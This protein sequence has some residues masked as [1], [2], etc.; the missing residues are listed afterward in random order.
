MA[1]IAAVFTLL[2]TTVAAIGA[3]PA[4]AQGLAEVSI[5]DI[6]VTE[7]N[8]VPP[9][10]YKNAL[11]T[12]SVSGPRNGS[13][14]VVY[15]TFDTGSATA[16]VD[17]RDFSQTVTISAGQS[18]VTRA[19]RVYGDT[20]PEPTETFEVRLSNP[21]NATIGNGTAVVTIND[22]DGYVP[23]AGPTISVADASVTEGDT[24]GTVDVSLTLS[25]AA[26]N[27]V[28]VDLATSNGS[29]VAGS[30]Y[31]AFSGTVTF[32]ANQTTIQQSIG[33]IGDT[34]FE[35]T[36]DFTVTL[37]N[38]SGATISDGSA[39]V[40]ITDN[41]PEPPGVPDLSVS[42][43]TVG[44]GDG[45]V[46]VTITADETS[47]SPVTFDLATADGT[48]TAGA[49]YTA[50]ST[51]VTLPANTLSV[52][53]VIT[54][55]EDT[56]SE[57]AEDFDVVISNVVGGTIV[58]GTGV[59]TIN[60]NDAPACS[61]GP[62]VTVGDVTVT[63]AEFEVN[64]L[65]TFTRS[66]VSGQSTRFF[67]DSID[68]TAVAPGDYTARS[69]QLVV[70]QG[71][72]TTKTLAFKIQGDTVAEP[73]ETFT[74]QISNPT[75][76][77]IDPNNDS[78][79]ITIVDNDG[80]AD[81]TISIS[82]ASTT[83]TDGTSSVDLTLSLDQTS[84][85]PV[86]VE[87]STQNGSAL[88]GSDFV[89]QAANTV[90]IP[91][92]NL[93]G[94]VSIDIIGDDD[95]EPTETFTVN[96][97]NPSGA[98]IGDGSATV[99]ILDD[100]PAPPAV[101]VEDASTT[102]TDGSSTVDV[103]V[104]LDQVAASPVTVLLSTSD[105]T[106]TAGADY[107]AVASQL[108]TIPAG[109]LNTNVA[110]SIVGDD[111][112]EPTE[113]FTVNI[114][115]P[116][117]AILGDSTGTVTIND[118]E[119]PPPVTPQISIADASTTETD[120]PS[121]VDVTVSLD[122]Q[123]SN[124]VTVDVATADGSAT[125]GNDYLAAGPTTVTFNPG[126]TQKT[127]SIDIVGDTNSEPVEDFAVNLSNP[128]LGVIADGSATVT[129][130]DN[131]APACS[132]GPDVTVGD[133]TVTETEFELNAIVTFTRAFS[134]NLS[135]RFFVNTI[136]GTA[137][138]PGDYTA[139]TNQLVVINGGQTTKTLAFKIQGDTVAEPVESF[140]VEISN[141][142][143]GCIDPNNNT[144]TVTIVDN[145]GPANPSVSVADVSTTE[146][147]GPSTV[148]ATVSIDFAI[149]NP[150]TVDLTTVDGTA[151]SGSDYVA[152]SATTVTIPAGQTSVAVPIGIVGDE[153]F[154]PTE[155]FT[156]NLTN[157]TNATIG[158]GTGTVTINDDEPT[159]PAVSIADATTTETDT[160]STVDVTVSLDNTSTNPVTVLLSTAD[161]T[162]TAPDDYLTTSGQLVTIP[163]NTSSVTVALDIVGDDIFEPT[164]SFTATLSSPTNAII[165]DGSATIT[166]TD[167][168]DPPPN[169][170][171]ADASTTETDTA[172]TVDVIVSLDATT[173]SPV[174]VLLS[175]SDGTA[176]AP[177]D[178]TAETNL[179]VTIPANTLS[180]TVP[181]NIAGDD[182]YEQTETFTVSLSS[183]T[184][185]FIGDG[186]AT[187]GILDDE[188][189]PPGAS[190]ADASV[191]ETDAATT[192]DLTITLDSPSPSVATVLLSTA[193]GTAVAP[194]DYTA[195]TDQL[196]TI[197]ANTSSVTVSLDI[198]GD[199]V[200]E[201][202]EEFTVTLSSPTNV[203]IGDGTATVTIT[204]NDP[205][206]P[207][208]PQISIADVSTT[209]TETSATVDVTVSFDVPTSNTVTVDL[210][211]ADGTALAGSDYTAAGP[212]TLT[213]APGD[214]S[215]TVT[216]DI[217]GDLV[218]ES[219]EDFTVNLSNAVDG[220]IAD[221]SATVTIF[222]ND[223]SLCGDG[224][225]ITVQDIAV[226]EG[227]S[228]TKN[229]AVTFNASYPRG[230]GEGSVRFDVNSINGTATAPSDFA[231]RTNQ[232]VVIAETATSKT[233]T[234]V[235]N[236]DTLEEGDESFLIEISNPL[237]G[238]IDPN[239][240]TGTFTILGDDG[241]PVPQISIADVTTAETNAPSTVDVTVSVDIPST[242]PITVQLDTVDGTAT[243]PGDYLA[244]VAQTVTIP[245]NATSVTYPLNIVGDMAFEQTEEFQ[246]AL[247]SPSSNAEIADGT[248]TVTITDADPAVGIPEIS[249]ADVTIAEDDV[250]VTATVTVT[251]DEVDDVPVT[252]Q[253]DTSDG[254]AT[255]PA[256]YTAVTAATV[257][258]PVGQLSATQDITIIGDDL[259]E[260]GDETFTVTLSNNSGDSI[261]ADP[262]ATVTITDD[263]F[264]APIPAQLSVLDVSVEESNGAPPGSTKNVVVTF[265]L[266][267]GSVDPVGQVR[268]MW[269]T[270]DTGSATEGTDYPYARSVDPND[271][272]TDV[273]VVIPAPVIG[274]APVTRTR[275]IQIY[276]DNLPEPDETFE[277]HLFDVTPN[278][279]VAKGIGVVT[280]ED[281]DGPPEISIDD[282]TVNEGDPNATLTLSLDRTIGNQIDVQVDTADG[283]AT[284]GSDYVAVAA[285]VVSFPANTQTVTV[286][287]PLLD[288]SAFE[289]DEDFTVNLS[290][291]VNA[292]IVD[293]QGVV[294]ISD[295]ESTPQISIG[296]VSA[297]EG[298]ATFKSVLLNITLD[299]TSSEEIT[300]RFGTVNGTAVGGVET[301]IPLPDFQRVNGSPTS[302]PLLTF[303]PGETTKT[304]SI[305][306]FGDTE[307]EVDE[308]FTVQLYAPT[309]ATFLDDSATVTIVD[310]DTTAGI[311]IDDLVVLE[312]DGSTPADFVLA[313]VT[314]SL[315]VSSDG[316]V[317]VQ[318]DSADGTAVAGTDYEAITA[319]PVTFPANTTTLTTEVKVFS[320]DVEDGNRDFVLNLSNPV[321]GAIVDG[322]AT[323]TIDDNEDLPK[324]SVADLSVTEGDG[325]APNDFVN[326]DVTVSLDSPS[327]TAATVQ[328]D[329]SAG[330]ATAG[331]DYEEVTAQTVT[332]PA[333]QTSVTQTIKVFG[334]TV[335][336]PD[337]DFTVTLSNPSANIDPG[338]MTATVTIVDNE[339]QP[340]LS[341]GDVTVTEGDTGFGFAVA[342]VTLSQVSN[343]NVDVDVDSSD[344]TATA[345]V[346]YEL[347]D[348]TLTIPAGS[349]SGQVFVKVFGDFDVESTEDLTLTLSNA[350]NGN[351]VDGTGT[352]TITDQ[353]TAPQISIG[354]ATVVE[355]DTGTVTVDLTLVTDFP[356]PQTVTVELSTADGTAT[357]GQDY[358][359]LSGVV[360][361]FTT[362]TDTTTATVTVIGDTD[363]EA[364]EDFTVNLSNP[365]NAVIADGS[366][367]VTID[368]DDVDPSKPNIRVED[369]FVTEGDANQSNVELVFILEQASDTT[370]RATATMEDITTTAG[371]GPGDGDYVPIIDLPLVFSPGDRILKRVI[372]INGDT[373]FE[374]NETARIILTPNTT[375][376]VTDD[377]NLVDPEGILT[378]LDSE[379]GPGDGPQIFIADVTQQE[380][381]NIGF[382][383][384]EVTFVL[385]E[386]SGAQVLFDV[387]AADGNTGIN[388]ATLAGGDYQDP[389]TH[390][391]MP[392]V[393]PPGEQIV[394]KNFRINGDTLLEGNE[395]FRL[396]V[397]NVQGGTIGD[398]EGI[399]TILDTDLPIGTPT[400]N[401]IDIIDGENGD[402]S[403]E[404]ATVKFFLDR[405]HD[406]TVTVDWQVA[407]GTLTAAGNGYDQPD[408]TQVVFLPGEQIAERNFRVNRD[409]VYTGSQ[410]ARAQI[411]NPTGGA[412]IGDGEG[413]VT[414]FDDEQD[415]NLPG[416][417]FTT[418]D[419]EES[420]AGFTIA[421]LK[422][423]IDR[424]FNGVVTATFGFID[425]TAKEGIDYGRH[426]SATGADITT[427]RWSSGE[428]VSET[429]A[430]IFSDNFFE[431]N[432][433]FQMELL[434]VT[435]DAQII[436][437]IGDI[438]IL[439]DED[440]SDP[441]E[442]SFDDADIA[443]AVSANVP[444]ANG[445]DTVTYTVDVTNNGPDEASAVESTLT[446]PAGLTLS[447]VG[448]C[449]NASGTTCTIGTLANGASSSFTVSAT[450]DNL[451]SG[452]VTAT[453]TASTED[454]DSPSTNN[455]ATVDVTAVSPYD[456]DTVY[457]S[458]TTNGSVGGVTFNDEDILAYDR[459]T[460]QWSL[461]F[462]GSDL[463]IITL[464][465]FNITDFTPG[466]TVIE[467]SMLSPRAIGGLPTVDDADVAR[468]TGTTGTNTSGTL[469]LVIDGSD[470]ALASSAENID[471]L[472]S[473]GV[474]DFAISTT[475][476][477]SVTGFAAKE[478]DLVLFD[479]TS[480]GNTTSGTLSM[481]FDGSTEAL[482]TTAEDIN[483]AYIDGSD[484]FL[485]F[486]GNV[487]ATGGFTA[488]FDD[489]VIQPGGGA[490]ELYFDGDLVGFG[491]ENID[492][493][494]IARS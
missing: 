360:A 483:G 162:A 140:L 398:G 425:G 253:L 326:A 214:T 357:A 130:T 355:G 277:I 189:V 96:L 59:I 387:A 493:I 280:I 374:G 487:T 494:H 54:V 191:T 419:I 219:T 404:I 15:N 38:P 296:D 289:G 2:A 338:T 328:L 479:P 244:E 107:V 124:T 93:T 324:V 180:T 239:D 486:F 16:D 442:P 413:I 230:L 160:A 155:T 383:N 335:V 205:I 154:E 369:I 228:A 440:P 164:E 97:A 216:L 215:K 261:L 455:T 406:Q 119:D 394:K 321:N 50:V 9:T 470:I 142:T 67:V 238:C 428:Q 402:T 203:I 452:V 264:V 346:D 91:A 339:V 241:P 114:S 103:T 122:Q 37:S 334:D 421:N 343:L 308:Q 40:T 474:D 31:D 246:V 345:G 44:E 447:S 412:I 167:D 88:G 136:D 269:E 192:V 466:A 273:P 195:V 444:T 46:T 363:F 193:D 349:T 283:T 52:T 258:I 117:N 227:D 350:V 248:A 58:D 19:I 459:S 378:I 179:V 254:T 99:T 42:D 347:V 39:T 249:I 380:G 174:T 451:T 464:D 222:D 399:V 181:L 207:V 229:V 182:V 384:V 488:D 183:P 17:Y 161:G 415:A 12:F 137:V 48:A 118:D 450:V 45:T 282:V 443:V 306:I 275:T 411:S 270:V 243:A 262:V 170:S 144:G 65:V 332:I 315:D 353:D 292:V 21:S 485:T 393:F 237:R 105:G 41:D 178:Y 98:F 92:G 34:D 18:S 251:I 284:A 196:V 33:I 256:D 358:Q 386:P 366:G 490:F 274:G 449:A 405:P 153:V 157:P 81:P 108:V 123:T 323:I 126:E 465:A 252:V 79:T 352:V 212:T 172:S 454:I 165:G 381:G 373:D 173:G 482:T 257:T 362:G 423:Y 318:V 56:T 24:A 197:P 265:E 149:L 247:S 472:A 66:A 245:A 300:V 210:A 69:G 8:G 433:T 51:S 217:L 32:P 429:K 294:T 11:V 351:I 84:V 259:D 57:P 375:P 29:A 109:N 431:G 291:P 186:L 462:D 156:L 304:V 330:T 329:T 285:Q 426:K 400:V 4:G 432:E 231:A 226:D 337:E 128:V 225:L 293:N 74:V 43:E 417:Y 297:V 133:I 209:E 477:L 7:I 104:S 112:F 190:I 101:S 427:I 272:N 418:T 372:K 151:V 356:V 147:D 325:A 27:P 85:N 320:N 331:T 266:A 202:T 255:A 106:A 213:F 319:R 22:N 152:E 132:D 390:L 260:G 448:G 131:D 218:P 116:T 150:V 476:N 395:V 379:V 286:D 208:R 368:E 336:E 163:A 359:A 198:A 201:Q 125:A 307:D 408:N 392:F 135:T 456:G 83:E 1:R 391:V 68:G 492:G 354:D 47:T 370:I 436:D 242:D 89:A 233:L 80:P 314:L 316:P 176:V 414:I 371:A 95:F 115:T 416:I 25:E 70:I 113:T 199:T 403:N 288:D 110:L 397:Q 127:V 187:I 446:L 473:S 49:D 484:R 457:V 290:N 489:I 159:P 382:N 463:G 424:P 445:G 453:A 90:T 303:L 367:T 10:A 166:I 188:P 120:G 348:Q 263:D 240:N 220:D 267:P 341:I 76:G 468:F 327:A 232:L 111:D 310:N 287:V 143:R 469:E 20:I 234:F 129:I 471:A 78:G 235:I 5:S 223:A 200:F 169:V 141:P 75:R 71:G 312:G 100:E 460:G 376:T 311:S 305:K 435:G 206:P 168:E 36:E 28:T 410:F 389:T 276:G 441:P 250:D 439:D 278:V 148:N 480:T 396:L 94:T 86:T 407:D 30:D 364:N 139:R 461:F 171:V 175:T 158:T 361:T 64:A 72:Q 333:G 204:D 13:L 211:T 138:A 302:G 3:S 145:D 6:S 26:P 221:G 82:D 268:F 224:P 134:T 73:V 53:Q 63:E 35:G 271:P 481:L 146:T 401:V 344:G 279:D 301:D 185:A 102:E 422:G 420:D 491:A 385:D 23:P 87:V 281:N 478:Q 409:D 467:F 61:D 475:S 55:L 458:S 377:A 299:S 295:S 340:D 438:I 317:T 430:R 342:S 194:D 309:N 60:D 437:A 121:T 322:Q 236:G 388:D 14:S 434:S 313:D 184:N 177:G 77:C 298:D 365:V 62:Y